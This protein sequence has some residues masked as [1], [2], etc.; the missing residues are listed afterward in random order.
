[1]VSKNENVPPASNL[2]NEK[3]DI[4][5]SYSILRAGVYGRCTFG[6]QRTMWQS[7]L[8]SAAESLFMFLPHRVLQIAYAM[9][10]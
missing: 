6:G 8:A 1:M 4:V 5:Q 10:F 9:S 3:L 2:H 7:V